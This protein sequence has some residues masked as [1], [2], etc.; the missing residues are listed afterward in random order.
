MWLAGAEIDFASGGAK[1]PTEKVGGIGASRYQP[2]RADPRLMPGGGRAW[3]GRIGSGGGWGGL[4]SVRCWRVARYR[5]GVW[6]PSWP[7]AVPPGPKSL[8]G[9]AGLA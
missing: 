4:S 8:S 9:Q 2:R 5:S 6:E 1:T 3:V 7:P